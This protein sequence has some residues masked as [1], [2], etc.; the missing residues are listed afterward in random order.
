VLKHGKCFCSRN[1]ENAFAAEHRVTDERTDIVAFIYK[2]VEFDYY[3]DQ[4]QSSIC[5]FVA[6]SMYI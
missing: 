6:H 5:S 3:E 4:A 1:I 2:I